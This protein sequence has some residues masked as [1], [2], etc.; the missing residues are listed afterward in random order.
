M[1]DPEEQV[2]LSK[3]LPLPGFDV[4]YDAIYAPRSSRRGK[5]DLQVTRTGED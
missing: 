3:A 5:P 2:P 1:G 4:V